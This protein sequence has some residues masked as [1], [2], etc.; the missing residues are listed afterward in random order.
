[1]LDVTGRTVLSRSV[2]A[3]RTGA[4]SL[5]VRD[6]AAGTCLARLEA[7]DRAGTLRLLVQKQVEKALRTLVR[8]APAHRAPAQ[9]G[10]RLGRRN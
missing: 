1:V 4:V 9:P 8:A 6:L 3:T 2:V 5:D 10:A 7:G